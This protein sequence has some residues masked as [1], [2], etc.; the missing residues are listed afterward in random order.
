[1]MVSAERKGLQE[2]NKFTSKQARLNED[3]KGLD[4]GKNMR[5]DFKGQKCRLTKK[6]SKK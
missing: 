2:K 5:F 1:M 4:Y 6:V 3:N